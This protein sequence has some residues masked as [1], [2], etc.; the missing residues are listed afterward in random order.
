MRK[1]ILIALLALSMF[2]CLFTASIF[3]QDLI[4]SSTDEFGTVNEVEGIT[5]TVE[6]RTAR[7]VLKN[8]D[9]TFSTF[10]TYYIYPTL[11]WQNG[12]TDANFKQLNN[13]L[14]TSYGPN[15]VVRLEFLY[16]CEYHEID[17]EMYKNLKEIH[18]PE[19]SKI[20]TIRRYYA[21]LDVLEKINIP[22]SVTALEQ[23]AFRDCIGLKEVVFDEGCM[24]K[25][26]TKEAFSGC[27]SLEEI[28][29]PDSVIR[30]E[31][32]AFSNCTALK[33]VRYGANLQFFA[34]RATSYA[35]VFY[36]PA[37]AMKHASVDM[38]K[39]YFGETYTPK[40]ATIFFTG[41]YDE[42]VAFRAKSTHKDDWNGTGGLSNAQI[43]E[44][45]S[46]KPDSYYVS[47]TAW[48]IVYSYNKCLAF[49]GGE[50]INGE[51]EYGFEGKKYL[52]S[53]VGFSGCTRCQSGTKE[54][55]CGPLFTA[56]GYS[57]CEEGAKGNITYGMYAHKENIAA[58][59]KF[60]GEKFIY[61]IIIAKENTEIG[62][63]IVDENG[64]CLVN[65][66]TFTDFSQSKYDLYS[67][68]DVKITGI[69]TDAQKAMRLYFGT[70]IVDNGN[71]FYL[72]EFVTAKAIAVSYN[73]I[74]ALQKDEQ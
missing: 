21:Y 61:G 30:V 70:Y 6:D 48:T 41:N 60:T 13:A 9:G 38:D 42:A 19:N 43:V 20:T 71:V 63:N 37:S 51:T 53:Y 7:I 69:T 25:V 62:G 5:S 57:V 24:L 67:S 15:S 68:Y 1:R 36:M 39:N 17:K 8:A 50:H 72:G 54:E 3:A 40:A 14:G 28:S 65:S 2:V 10:Y 34:S 56:K 59:E 29:L 22:P 18:F 11:N 64:Q 23:N 16:D 49:Y 46:E 4:K 58:Y 73:S 74:H 33:T 47:D 26:I 55:I 12:M 52:S 66:M 35:T 45:D 31:T 32:Q 44:W 27:T